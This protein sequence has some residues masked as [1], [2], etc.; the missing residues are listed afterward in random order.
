MD[1]HENQRSD[2]QRSILAWIAAVLVAFCCILVDAYV[3]SSIRASSRLFE[4][5]GG[6][7]PLLTLN[8]TRHSSPIFCSA[9]LRGGIF[10]YREGDSITRFAGPI[11]CHRDD[12]FGRRCCRRIS[13][14]HTALAAPLH[15]G[16]G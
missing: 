7:L 13:A 10:R 6:K 12:I 16:E 14:I 15:G 3:I 9:F 1:E 11:V 8:A 4:G 5:F 2:R